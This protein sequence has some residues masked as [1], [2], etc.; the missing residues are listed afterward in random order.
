MNEVVPEEAI[1]RASHHGFRNAAIGL[2]AP[3]PFT[4]RPYSDDWYAAQRAIRQPKP[5]NQ[6]PSIN[7]MRDPDSRRSRAKAVAQEEAA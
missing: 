3:P 4:P 2:P 6:R 7:V 1:R 5:E